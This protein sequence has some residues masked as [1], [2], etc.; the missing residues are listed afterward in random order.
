VQT[1]NNTVPLVKGR[2]GLLRVFV[3]ANQ[4]NVAAPQ[5]RVRLYTTPVVLAAPFKTYMIPA[6]GL[7]V[8]TT[9]DES[10]LTN[11]WN[12]AIPASDIG[13]SLHILVDVD[14]GNTVPEGSETDNLWPV[15]GTPAAQDVRAVQPLNIKFVPI[16]QNGTTGSVSGST[17]AS[18]T[19]LL[20][21]LHP[22]PG[23]TTS[24]RG[25]ITMNT[26]LQPSGSANNWSEA[27]DTLEQ[28]RVAD[29]F[30]GHYYGLVH[31]TY[32][33]GIAGLGYVGAVSASPGVPAGSSAMGWDDPGTRA[34]VMAHEVGHNFNR[35]HTPCPGTAPDPASMDP[36]YPYTTGDIGAYGFK[37]DSAKQVPTTFKDI[38]SYCQPN[39]WI[40][41][42][43]YAGELTY[44]ATSPM[45]VTSSGQ[46]VQ[47]V[48]FVTGNIGASGV[49]IG[50]AYQLT[51]RP[52]MPVSSGPYAVEGFDANGRQ[53]FSVRFAPAQIADLPD[54]L[55]Q[56]QHFT[57]AIPAGT[58]NVSQLASLRVR[59]PAGQAVRSSKRALAFS[60]APAPN[61][62]PAVQAVGTNAVS[63]SWD[64]VTYPTAIVRDPATGETLGFGSG[65]R[66]QVNSAA[67]QLE[68][69]VS[70]G[71]QSHTVPATVPGR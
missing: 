22:V 70:D 60:T 31:V 52:A 28:F 27:L 49:S 17:V 20:K 8:P 59:G 16:T 68:L 62:Q 30:T 21:E 65:G 25:A 1:L 58:A 36:N 11:S 41:D 18:D 29:G 67:R 4:T 61:A 46:G 50:P 45:V 55:A 2:N 7:S 66:I 13:N 35:F 40:S 51:T 34:R 53:L 57:F 23:I 37:I 71:V 24:I 44:R 14:P 39:Q 54:G 38:M 33:S 42:Y 69:V 48:L 5:V 10:N 3:K 12:V 56:N 32:Q 6:P 47:P 63:L 19:V 43:T 9:T 15:N 26:V 64:A